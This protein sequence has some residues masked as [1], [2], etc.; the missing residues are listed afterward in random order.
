MFCFFTTTFFVSRRGR[1][2]P[3]I[4]KFK[5]KYVQVVVVLSSLVP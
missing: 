5:G 4:Y 3:F 1:G 2:A